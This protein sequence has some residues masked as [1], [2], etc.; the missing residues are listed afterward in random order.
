MKSTVKAE[1]IKLY[2]I[3]SHVKY[4]RFVYFH[5]ITCENIYFLNILY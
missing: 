1:V 3:F 2:A 5:I 4:N